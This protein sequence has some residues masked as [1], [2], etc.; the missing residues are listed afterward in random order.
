MDEQWRLMRQHLNE[1]S[2]SAAKAA[3]ASTT[4]DVRHL[5][6]KAH[7]ELLHAMFIREHIIERDQRR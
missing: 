2:E 6:N 7:T 5:S 4:E 3:K 1:A